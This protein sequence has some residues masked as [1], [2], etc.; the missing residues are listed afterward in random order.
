MYPRSRARPFPH[1]SSLQLAGR[2]LQIDPDCCS[3]GKARL[4]IDRGLVPRTN[5][6]YIPQF[7]QQQ[8]EL[9]ADLQQLSTRAGLSIRAKIRQPPCVC[10][11]LLDC[12]CMDREEWW[13]EVVA[14]FL[15]CSQPRVARCL[16]LK[17]KKALCIE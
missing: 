2:T 4:I 5:N 16:L 14:E 7:V 3:V 11:F 6:L 1:G 15:S 8:M 13:L 10:E 17:V 12:L 9:A